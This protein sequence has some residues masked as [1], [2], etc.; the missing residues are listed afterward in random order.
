MEREKVLE[1]AVYSRRK[2]TPSP[3]A[4]YEHHGRENLTT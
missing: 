4:M 3:S 2:L 1:A